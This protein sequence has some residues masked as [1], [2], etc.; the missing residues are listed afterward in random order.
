MPGT[1]PAHALG[2]HA[3]HAQQVLRVGEVGRQ[4]RQLR[5]EVRLATG[6]RCQR[7][8]SL[9][10]SHLPLFPYASLVAGEETG[11]QVETE[12]EKGGEGPGHT[13]CLAL[14]AP[15]ELAI[16]ERCAPLL[17]G[18]AVVLFIAPRR[19]WIRVYLRARE[20]GKG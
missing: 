12:E 8:M 1:Q 5:V 11:R 4:L 2:L 18:F 9:S 15:P 14:T 16:E 17:V 13:S 10:S 19:W 6:G 3:R 20:R 7:A